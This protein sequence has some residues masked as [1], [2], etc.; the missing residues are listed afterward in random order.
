MKPSDHLAYFAEHPAIKGE[1]QARKMSVPLASITIL[2]N[3]ADKY[4]SP[5]MVQA[6]SELDI[7]RSILESLNMNK[8]AAYVE[9]IYE[10]INNQYLNPTK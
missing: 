1:S 5:A 2:S 3:F 6:L 9:S 7:T 8:E 10:Y 4:D